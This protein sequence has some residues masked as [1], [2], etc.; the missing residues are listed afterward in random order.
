M[1]ERALGAKGEATRGRIIDSALDLFTAHGYD[2]TTMRAI[3]AAA[4]VS[5]GSSYQYF[6]GK[7]HL[8]QAFYERSQD[9]HAAAVAQV[10]ATETDFAVRLHAALTT[11]IDTMQPYRAFASAF[12]RVASDPDSP[13]SPFSEQSAPA[14]AAAT[15]IYEDVVVGADLRLAQPLRE[16]L[17]RLLWLLQM[18]I[19]LFW[20]HDRSPG[21]SRTYL[22]IDRTVPLV[23]RG[24]RV[25]RF[26]LL[27]P[28]VSDGIA[29]L[30]D[31]AGPDAGRL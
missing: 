22:L 12:F 18:G 21:A 15:A 3:A 29:L 5:L 24:L 7:D 13:L 30:D 27:Q 23:A 16:R 1:S 11:R 31:F 14:R 28:L 19:V 17:P 10:L 4:G 20:V 6:A 26:R 25:S 8:V 2:G 9:E